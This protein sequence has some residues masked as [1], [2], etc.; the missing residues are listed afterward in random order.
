MENGF[1]LLSFSKRKENILL[2]VFP[3]NTF[4]FYENE[5]SIVSRSHR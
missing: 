5:K 2:L 4:F 3:L 1:F